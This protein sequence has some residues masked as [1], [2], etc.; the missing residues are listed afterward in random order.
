MVFPNTKIYPVRYISRDLYTQLERSLKA[1]S[2]KNKTQISFNFEEQYF[3]IEGRSQ[4]ACEDT[5][6]R[7]IQ[8]LLPRLNNDID[9]YKLK[10]TY[11]DISNHVCEPLDYSSTNNQPITRTYS[12]TDQ[13]ADEGSLDSPSGRTLDAV[14]V[15]T[16]SHPS[17]GP[18]YKGD[19]DDSDDEYSHQRPEFK[20]SF[21]IAKNVANP[22]DI[23]VGPPIGNL[24]PADYLKIVGHD[25]DTECCLVGREVQITGTSEDNVKDA[26]ERFKNLQTLYKRRRKGTTVLPCVHYPEE[27]GFYELYFCRLDQ[28]ALKNMVYLNEDMPRS[29]HVLLPVFKDPKTGEYK[30]PKDLI[31]GTPAPVQ[32]KDN[33]PTSQS[34]GSPSENRYDQALNKT[35]HM[36]SQQLPTAQQA[37]KKK[38]TQ[39]VMSSITTPNPR[40]AMREDE[41]PLWG[42]NRSFVNNWSAVSNTTFGSG[43]SFT[44]TNPSGQPKSKPQDEFPSLASTAPKPTIAPKKNATPRRVMRITPQKANRNEPGPETSLLEMQAPEYNQN[45]MRNALVE[46]LRGVQGFKGEI[47]FSAKLGKVLWGNLKEDVYKNMWKFQDIKDVVVNEKGAVPIFNNGTTTSEEVYR[48]IQT[49]PSQS[50]EKKTYF[51]MHAD[52]RN[53]PIL[54]YKRVVMYMSQGVV[55]LDK[56]VIRNKPVTEIDWISLDRIFD[57]QMSLKTQEP[58]RSDVKPYTT[59]IKKVAATLTAGTITYEDIPDFLKVQDVLHKHTTRY[60]LHYPFI[61]EITRI[62]R[63]SRIPQPTMGITSQKILCAPTGR[64]VWY[65]VEVLYSP[66]KAAF[67]MNRKLAVGKLASWTVET[68]L[69]VDDVQLIDYVRCMLSLTEKCQAALL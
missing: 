8:S 65:D 45:N 64:E 5:E 40:G 61:I 2:N 49:L 31:S 47:S 59:F 14:I 33:R 60:R 43:S 39:Q 26:L 16:P 32:P 38:P 48:T 6:S 20:D 54:P 46:G 22:Q 58:V 63:L 53:Q 25:T 36:V 42:E 18:Y 50:F 62:E 13:L 56:V 27:S 57:F 9:E 41:A 19:T 35:M 17:V 34:W 15:P 68:I 12:I 67:D 69:G 3:D 55:Q 24:Q 7:I 28:Y 10:G 52:V 21:V 11:N 51:E 1:L 37:A 66:H 44:S 4:E 29:L 30:K 23:L